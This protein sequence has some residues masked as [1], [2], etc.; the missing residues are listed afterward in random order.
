[1]RRLL[2][3]QYALFSNKG[4]FQVLSACKW[5]QRWDARVAT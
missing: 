3:A 2:R 1:M 4:G 5:A